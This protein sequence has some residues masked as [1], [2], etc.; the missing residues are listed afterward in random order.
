MVEIDQHPLGKLGP[1]SNKDQA[2]IAEKE[3]LYGNLSRLADQPQLPLR[4]ERPNEFTER[5]PPGTWRRSRWTNDEYYVADK[6]RRTACGQEVSLNVA[7]IERVVSNDSPEVGY[8]TDRDE[9]DVEIGIA[10]V[11][12][13]AA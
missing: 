6:G 2:M 1:Y 8:E 5:P 10:G 3:W 13:S 12:A 11:A 7:I 4:L 9:D